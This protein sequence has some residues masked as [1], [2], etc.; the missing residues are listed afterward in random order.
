MSQFPN[1]PDALNLMG[2][3]N[4]AG[5]VERELNNFTRSEAHFTNALTIWASWLRMHNPNSSSSFAESK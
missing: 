2:L 5:L 4:S 1:Q 3:M